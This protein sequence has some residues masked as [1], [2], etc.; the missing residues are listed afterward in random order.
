MAGL[1]AVEEAENTERKGRRSGFTTE[2]TESTEKEDHDI[3]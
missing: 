3:G 2:I 1:F